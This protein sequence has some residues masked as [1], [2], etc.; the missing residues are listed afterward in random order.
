MFGIDPVYCLFLI[1]GLLLSLFASWM[2]KSTFNKYSK[3]RGSKGLTGAEAARI[4]LE[5]NG[6]YDCRIE[7]V[8]GFLT[9][10]YDPRDKTLR[11]SEEVYSSRSLSAIGVACHEAGHALQHAM[12]YP[13]LTMRSTLVP[14]VGIC[15]NL[16]YFIIIAGLVFIHSK[17]LI[18]V[19]CVLFAVSTLFTIIT[20]PVEWDASARAKRAM[21]TAGLVSPQESVHS[22]KV[23]NAAFMTYLASAIS[24]VLTLLY[25]LMKAGVIG[26]GNSRD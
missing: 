9:D 13:F 10:H 17:E 1:P 6:V 26:G 20:L 2:T 24:S 16:G 25:Y 12:A 5:R 22:G 19:G 7:P 4:M 21:L 3:V 14:L 23:L 15:S 18:L 8:S 11:L